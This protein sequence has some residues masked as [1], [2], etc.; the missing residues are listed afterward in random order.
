MT[1]SRKVLTPSLD[2]LDTCK[3]VISGETKR[4][5]LSQKGSRGRGVKEKSSNVSNIE[6]VKNGA[7]PSVMGDYRNAAKEVVL[8]SVVDETM[9]ATSA[10][11]APGKRVAYHV[12]ANY[13]RNTWD[14]YRL[15]RSMF[16]SSTRLFSF[17]FSSMDGLN[18]ML[19]N[20]WVKLHGVPITAFSDDGLSAIATKLADVELKVNIVA[21]MPKITGEGY[22]TCNIRVE[23]EWKPPRCA[24]C[25]N[26]D[27]SSP[28]TTPIMEKIDKIEKLIIDGKVTLVDKEGKPFKKVDSSCDYDSE[29]EI[30]LEQWTESYENNDY[31]YDLYDDDMYKVIMEYLVKISK[32]ARILELKRRHL[33]ITVLTSNTPYPS[34]K[35]RHI[36]ACTSQKTTKETRSIRQPILKKYTESAQAES[37]PT[38][39]NTDDDINI[40]LSKEFL[41]ELKNNAYHGMFDEDVV[42]HIAKVLELVDLIKIP[43]VDSH[44]LRMKVFLLSLAD[45]AR[46]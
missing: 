38:E 41:M 23:Y 28:R 5:F 19:G 31:G 2:D 45:D 21:A 37:N 20:V 24:Y 40:E 15:V 36:Y 12:V 8:P 22:Y 39:P 11:N 46:Q 17:Q 35:I 44:Q 32:K 29:D 3:V 16:S 9:E 4:G 42:D 1:A 6:V 10:G 13:I 14:K 33:K 25:K 7:V 18:A 43:G 27:A 34:R 26:V 30:L